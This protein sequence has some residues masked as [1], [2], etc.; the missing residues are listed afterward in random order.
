MTDRETAGEIRHESIADAAEHGAQERQVRLELIVPGRYNRPITEAALQELAESVRSIGVLQPILV[1]LLPASRLEETADLD[2]RPTYEIVAGE[3]RYRAAKLVGLDSIPV[4]ERPLTDAQVIEAQ[5]VENLQREKLHPLDEA[6]AYR[7]LIDEAGVLQADIAR[8]I[9]KGKTYVSGRMKLLALT[10]ES[11]QAF[12]EERGGLDA[13]KAELLATVADTK[14]QAKALAVF[15]ETTHQGTPRHS[16]RDCRD[17]IRDNIL[18][19]IAEAPFDRKR[20]DLVE[21]CPACSDCT[22]RTHADQDLLATF[23]G[24]DLCLEPACFRKKEAAGLAEIKAKAGEQGLEVIAGSAAKKLKSAYSSEIKGYTRLDAKH[25]DGQG[26][27]VTIARLLGKDAPAPK[28]F[29]DPKTQKAIKVLPTEVVGEL[30]KKRGVVDKT[31]GARERKAQLEQEKRRAQEAIELRTRAIAVDQV[32]AQLEAGVL[33]AFSAPLLRLLLADTLVAEHGQSRLGDE[34]ERLLLRLWRLPEVEGD[35]WDARHARLDHLKARAQAAVDEAVGVMFLQALIV[36]D[37]LPSYSHPTAF[38]YL[39][40]LAGETAIDLQACRALAK[41][42]HKEALL[43]A[44]KAAE[45]A[46][47]APPPPGATL[48]AA[49]Q[50]LEARGKGKKAGAT[51]EAAPQRPVRAKRPRISAE[52]AKQGIALA[53]QG[54]ERPGGQEAGVVDTATQPLFEELPAVERTEAGGVAQYTIAGDTTDVDGKLRDTAAEVLL[55]MPYVDEALLEVLRGVDLADPRKLLELT[56]EEIAGA[57]GLEVDQAGELLKACGSWPWA[58][59]LA[60]GEISRRTPPTLAVGRLVRILAGD[61]IDEDSAR[62]RWIGKEGEVLSF[63]RDGDGRVELDV[64]FKLP[65]GGKVVSFTGDQVEVV[66]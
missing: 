34:E 36:R 62:R 37:L 19:R 46:E 23:D 21:G 20:S 1:R 48:Q 6:D 7:R 42:E 15:C 26:G 13:S 14:L 35:G 56:V 51:L 65:K 61:T 59:V 58:T 11:R 22:K 57:T 49:P 50:G 18:L 17:W 5:L 12:R 63:S 29:I 41:A 38:P 4:L 31:A 39:Q 30:L 40:Q 54:D 3:R 60:A 27:E 2:P 10:P 24:P 8:K 64:S 55:G 44:K 33:T 52:E 45:P 28:L 43:A 25:D 53:M 16:V 32:S 9:G 47:D 66:Q